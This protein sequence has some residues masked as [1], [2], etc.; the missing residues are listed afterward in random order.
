[1]G[2]RPTGQPAWWRVGL[3]IAVGV[4]VALFAWLGG[5]RAAVAAAAGVLASVLVVLALRRPRALP[6]LSLVHVGHRRG[7]LQNLQST[8]DSLTAVL[9]S[10]AQR[11]AVKE[12][13]HKTI[14][15]LTQHRDLL[16]TLRDK[17]T[18]GTDSPSKLLSSSISVPGTQLDAPQGPKLS[19]KQVRKQ[20]LDADVLLFRGTRP[21]SRMLQVG[22]RSSY[23]H[24]GLVAWWHRRA[25]LL[26]AESAW[27][28]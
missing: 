20:L 23:S 3:G 19:Y 22:A 5:Q 18:K 15:A 16:I 21:I 6:L 1:M 11:G 8:I 27:P 24:C 25:M 4:T 28:S 14:H 12:A 7:L 2:S 26:H 10:Q 13:E 9:D 17:H